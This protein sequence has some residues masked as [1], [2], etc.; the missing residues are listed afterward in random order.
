MY[1]RSALD[2]QTRTMES[3]SLQKKKNAFSTFRWH[4][5]CSSRAASEDHRLVLCKFVAKKDWINWWFV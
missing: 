2:T 1:P 3:V 5:W 4:D